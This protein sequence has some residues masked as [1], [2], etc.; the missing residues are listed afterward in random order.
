MYVTVTTT[1]PHV[2]PGDLPN[3]KI[4][5]LEDA[6]NDGRADKSTVFAEG[7]N[8]PT[9]I[10]LGEGGV[11]VGQGTELLF[12]QDTDGDR[13]ADKRKVLLSGFGSGDTHQTINSFVWGPGGELYIGQG[14]GIESR[15]ETP[16]GASNLFRSGFYRLRPKRLQ[17]LPFLED[18]TG[19][20]NPWGVVFDRWGQIFSSDGA[21]GISWLSPT[22]SPTTQ[23]QSYR[24]IGEKGGYCGIDTLDGR[25]L[26]ESMHGDFVVNHFRSNTVKRFSVKREGSGFSLE[27]K[28]PVLQSR[29]RNFLPV[30]VRV[31]PDGA[32]YVVDWYNPI[33]CHQDDAYR[34]PTR[35]K[36]H[37]RIWRISSAAPA[38]KPPK[39]AEATI[40]ELL[41]ALSA[42]EHWTRYQAKRA[43]TLAGIW[44]VSE[45]Q[46]R[47]LAA[48]SSDQL[49]VQ[50]RA[51]AFGAL[52]DMQEPSCRDILGAYAEAPNPPALRAAAVR[53]LVE[54]DVEA[55]ARHAADL[56]AGGPYEVELSN[57]SAVILA[58]LNRPGGVEALAS[59]LQTAQLESAAA[60]QL[61]RA[62]FSTGRSDKI[63]FDSLSQSMGAQTKTPDYNESYVRQVAADASKQGN[64]NDGSLRFNSLACTSCH[65]VGGATAPDLT[66]IGTTLSAERIVEE[67]LWPN[68]QIKEG[69]TV[70]QVLTDSGKIHQGYQR[71]TKAS[72]ASGDV[73]I[74]KLDSQETLLIK[75]EHIEETQSAGSPMPAGLTSLLTRSQ[76]LDLI[77]YLS[78][79]GQ[80]K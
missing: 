46:Q 24:V 50:V 20:G 62:L 45:T 10:E 72:Q 76:L 61:V 13:Q 7:L 69:F 64:A 16:W 43:L 22:L 34:D 58:F 11:Y 67:L 18:H 3:D 52:V 71:H 33:T 51:A 75:R 30:D 38:L 2:F 63:L 65:K 1:Y 44:Q 19:V 32:I 25:H 68:R 55:A 12:L 49:P 40:D 26:P 78:E 80:I 60:M 17:L 35:D 23:G 53:S 15:V 73:L 59:A 54:V 70:V 9:G 21:G 4:I 77:R 57:A 39:L 6:D 14:D 36:A 47:V 79:L 37:G 42:P 29:H 48:A 41:D 56:F 66:S 74:Q 27:W 28:E 8:I 31:G 5:V